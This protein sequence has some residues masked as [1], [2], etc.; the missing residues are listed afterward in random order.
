MRPKNRISDVASLGSSSMTRSS[1]I[2]SHAISMGRNHKGRDAWCA[3]AGW[4]DMNED[5]A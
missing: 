5:Y 3:V 4:G 2:V 1:A